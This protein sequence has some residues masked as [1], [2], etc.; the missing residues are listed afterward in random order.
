MSEYYDILGVP[1]GA[2]ISEIRKAYR[3]LALKYHPDINKDPSAH[4][5]FIQI[6]EAYEILMGQRT[7]KADRGSNASAANPVDAARERAK[8]YA[9]MRYEEFKRQSDAYEQTPM[10]RILWPAWVNVVIVLFCL[11]FI[12]DSL[13]P[14]RHTTGLA[15][16]ES[17]GH[18]TVNGIRFVPAYDLGNYDLSGAR[19][20]LYFTPLIGYAHSYDCLDDHWGRLEPGYSQTDYI[21]MMYLLLVLAVITLRN[22]TRKFENKLLIKVSMSIIILA[23]LLV[24][25][26]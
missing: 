2:D 17:H 10:H 9:R 11:L 14:L 15:R 1:Y 21:G 26:S 25:F 22:K 8:A 18:F 20:T 12:T 6:T 4:Q 3:R 19:V 16:S 7:K 5:Q 24:Y 23:Y 13:M